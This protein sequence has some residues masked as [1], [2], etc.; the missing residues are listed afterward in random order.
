MSN[1]TQWIY[2]QNC[3]WHFNAKSQIPPATC[4]PGR[5]P[6]ENF[7]QAL[8]SSFA[9]AAF[10]TLARVQTI[11]GLTGKMSLRNM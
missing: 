3:M 4:D 11:Y 7:N 5:D 10:V 2:T 6:N 1:K 8:C 9:V